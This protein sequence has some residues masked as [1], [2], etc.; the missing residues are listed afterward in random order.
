MKEYIDKILGFYFENDFEQMIINAQLDDEE[1]AEWGSLAVLFDHCIGDISGFSDQRKDDAYCLVEAL[2]TKLE[3]DL[4]FGE[5]D[6]SS[7]G[8]VC[9]GYDFEASE[10]GNAIE[11]GVQLI[12]EKGL[13]LYHLIPGG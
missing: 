7:L 6:K 3:V 11:S 13:N 1:I 10:F 5:I 2:Y 9:E 8:E 12:E 4:M